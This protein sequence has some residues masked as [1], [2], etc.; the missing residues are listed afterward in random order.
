MILFVCEPKCYS[1]TVPEAG[2]ELGGCGF[3]R[4]Q[5]LCILV[6]V[7]FLVFGHKRPFLPV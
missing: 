7:G 5:A 6:L 4:Q 2:P 1:I 3:G